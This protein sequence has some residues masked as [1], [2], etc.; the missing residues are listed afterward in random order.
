MRKV[1]PVILFFFVLLVTARESFSA[2]TL[3][4]LFKKGQEAYAAK[5]YDT[6]VS[7]FLQVADM[8]LAAKQPAKAQLVLGSNVAVIQLQQEKF[9]DSLA[10]YE[11]AMA[12]PGKPEE[13]FLIKAYRNLAFIHGKLGNN[14]QKALEFGMR[15]LRTD[16]W[17]KVREGKTTIEEV[18]RVTRKEVY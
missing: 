5:Q 9:T 11:K 2:P 12:I 4:D 17:T 8:L 1:V 10:T 15:S 7:F 18:L 3:E 6:A 13:A 14:A 16:G